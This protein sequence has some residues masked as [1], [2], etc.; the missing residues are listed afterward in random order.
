[1]ETTIAVVCG[2]VLA[3]CLYGL[4]K[5]WPVYAASVRPRECRHAHK[6]CF[7]SVHSSGYFAECQDCGKWLVGKQNWDYPEQWR[8]DWKGPDGLWGSK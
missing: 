1:M 6:K 3:L 2:A 7:A 5:L 4:F 8:A